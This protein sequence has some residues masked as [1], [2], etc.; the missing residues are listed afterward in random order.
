MTDVCVCVWM[1]Y[2]AQRRLAAE[3]QAL[4]RATPQP[5][6][7]HPNDTGLLH[8]FAHCPLNLFL[9]RASSQLRHRTLT[10]RGP[11]GTPYSG[12]TF[13]VDLVFPAG[14]ELSFPPITTHCFA[15]TPSQHI[16]L[17]TQSTRSAAQRCAS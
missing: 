13:F 4:Q 15:R 9:S 11:P 3:H 17:I 7:A 5:Y 10:L 1:W 6:V 12:G 2:Q 8:W 14:L 16:S